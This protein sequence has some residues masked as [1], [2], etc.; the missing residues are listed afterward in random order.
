[1][2]LNVPK[3]SDTQNYLAILE[4]FGIFAKVTKPEK[5]MASWLN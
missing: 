4:F 5:C 2:C 3:F 1:M